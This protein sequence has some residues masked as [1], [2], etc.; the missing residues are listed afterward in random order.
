[1]PDK[2]TDIYIWKTIERI[3]FAPKGKKDIAKWFRQY[4]K[5]IYTLW[6]AEPEFQKKKNIAFNIDNKLTISFTTPFQL[7]K[8]SIDINQGEVEQNLHYDET[9]LSELDLDEMFHSGIDK[10]LL[11]DLKQIKPNK[12]N[13]Y[14]VLN[15]MIV[16]PALHLHFKNISHF[17]RLN[18]NTKN[19]FLFLYQLAFQLTDY[20]TDF[21]ESD[22]KNKEINRLT[23]IAFKN[24]EAQIPIS[25]GEL[26]MLNKH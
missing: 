21:R 25:S 6:E 17:V 20:A 26:F 8:F 18:T 12:D 13:I 10:K 24:I 3:L 22:I 16:H 23:D 14:S 4:S 15:S 1:M 19:P 9:Y 7:P 11:R 5:F 2:I